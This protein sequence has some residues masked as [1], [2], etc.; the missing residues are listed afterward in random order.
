MENSFY[1]ARTHAQHAHEGPAYDSADS[2]KRSAPRRNRFP[3]SLVRAHRGATGLSASLNLLAGR[4]LSRRS[5]SDNLP[6]WRVA[7]NRNVAVNETDNA[8]LIVN[9]L[10]LSVRWS[11]TV[12]VGNR[13]NMA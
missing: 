12:F 6:V 10:F 13:K 5:A 7:V 8:E 9:I 1:T 3:F 4:T 11:C 2:D